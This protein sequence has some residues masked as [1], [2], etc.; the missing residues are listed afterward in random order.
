MQRGF[1]PYR[2]S[3]RMNFMAEYTTKLEFWHIGGFPKKVELQQGR[4]VTN[5]NNP[6][7]LFIMCF[8]LFDNKVR[9]S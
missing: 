3:Q 4:S 8:I 2:F 5:R 7:N 1:Y 6:S 9:Y